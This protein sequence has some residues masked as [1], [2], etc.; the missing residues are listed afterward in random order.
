MVELLTRVG[1]EFTERLGVWSDDTIY[2]CSH[3]YK[4]D[5]L[6]GWHSSTVILVD[7]L[8]VSVIAAP[9]RCVLWLRGTVFRRIHYGNMQCFKTMFQ[10][11]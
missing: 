11:S 8:A 4:F 3:F 7:I 6:G 5:I 10:G 2:G 9:S 1:F